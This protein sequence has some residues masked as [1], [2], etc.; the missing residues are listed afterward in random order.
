[1][2]QEVDDV[3]EEQQP[4]V[5]VKSPLQPTA[6]EVAE[7]E[8]TGHVV[9]RSWC[10]ICI[11]A[12][13]HGQPHRAAPAEDDTAVPTI[14]S[15]YGFMGQDD[16]KSLPMLCIKDRRTKRV[17]ATFLESKGNTPYGVKF[18]E[19]FL[20]STGYKRVINKSDG[21]PGMVSLKTKAAE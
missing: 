10:P 17:A 1:M 8:A 20:R 2:G 6:A 21:E 5:R 15:D 16:G 19:N 13:G 9:Y 3:A 12:R 18:F 7:H 4:A 11:A 14:M